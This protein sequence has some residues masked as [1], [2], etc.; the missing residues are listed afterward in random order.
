[1]PDAKANKNGGFKNA[2]FVEAGKRLHELGALDPFQP[3]YLQT[4]HAQSAG[5][6][7]DGKAAMDL[8]GQWLLG[9]QA[10]NSASGKGLPEDDIGILSFPT[11]PDGKGKATDTMG[12]INGFLVTKSAPAEAVDFLKFFSQKKYAEEAAATGAYI[13]VVK[14]AEAAITDPLQRRLADDLAASTY[15]Q[16]YLDQDLG[17]SLGGVINEISVAVAAGQTTPE[18]AAAALQ[19]AAEQQ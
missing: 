1:V 10:P 5:V 13:P 11:V 16:N 18:A 8:M 12:G 9:M 17:P 14:G 2:T 15:H 3:G 7:G 19:E 6:F 4:S